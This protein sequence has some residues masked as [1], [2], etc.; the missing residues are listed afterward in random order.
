ML[1]V[2]ERRSQF[3]EVAGVEFEAV[4]QDGLDAVLVQELLGAF[5][6]GLVVVVQDSSV[7][8]KDGFVEGSAIDEDLFLRPQAPDQV[9]AEFVSIEQGLRDAVGRKEGSGARRPPRGVNTELEEAA[10]ENASDECSCNR[11]GRQILQQRRVGPFPQWDVGPNHDGSEDPDERD[12]PV[13][14]EGGYRE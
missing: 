10:G 2:G 5:T 4:H 12:V 8:L 11:D 6:A 7:V 1:G 3:V 13:R 9:A 14:G